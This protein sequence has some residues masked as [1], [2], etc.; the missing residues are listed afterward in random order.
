MCQSHL[1][2]R[3]IV[4]R[5]DKHLLV[6]L[7]GRVHGRSMWDLW[8]FSLWFLVVFTACFC[9]FLV[10]CFFVLGISFC[11]SFLWGE[12][13]ISHVNDLTSVYI[14]ICPL[15]SGRQWLDWVSTRY[16][17]AIELMSWT[18]TR[19]R[20]SRVEGCLTHVSLRG[21]PSWVWKSVEKENLKYPPRAGQL[22]L[23]V[24]ANKRSAS[25]AWGVW[26]KNKWRGFP[27]FSLRR[28]RSRTDM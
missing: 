12:R 25:W 15:F 14:C 17:I 26:N 3:W 8:V 20:C 10:C 13:F 11:C 9:L 1:L 22:I 18:A 28:K 4:C 24:N 16:K 21:L 19:C 7:P 2:K 27:P 6:Q 23:V 5:R